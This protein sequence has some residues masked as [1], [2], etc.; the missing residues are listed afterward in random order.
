MTRRADPW[1]MGH[2]LLCGQAASRRAMAAHLGDC[3]ASHAPARGRTGAVY[4]L[5]VDAGRDLPHWLDLEI[6]GSASLEDLDRFLRDTWLECCGHMSE[7][8]IDRERFQPAEMLDDDWGGAARSMGE[9]VGKVFGHLRS[10]ARFRH[11]YDPGSPT[12][13]D[14]RIGGVRQGSL[15]GRRQ[16]RLLARNDPEELQCSKCDAVATAV[17]SMCP[18]PLF[19]KTHAAR[20]R[21]RGGELLPVVDSPRMGV[22]AYTGPSRPRRRG[23]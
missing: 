4:H 13:L 5:R 23:R 22:C 1:P 2:C 16:L 19:C 7:F 10:N 17:C 11:V 14:L 8:R 21:C 15:P 3:A 6:A 9:P 18:V 12:L 20:H